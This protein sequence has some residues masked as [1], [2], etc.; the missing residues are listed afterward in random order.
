MTTWADL[1]NSPATLGWSVINVMRAKGVSTKTAIF[2]AWLAAE[3]D[4]TGT[5]TDLTINL[6]QTGID[7]LTANGFATFDGT[8][9]VATHLDSDG[10]GRPAHLRRVPG[11]DFAL[12]LN[13]NGVKPTDGT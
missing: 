3:H 5:L 10:S 8:T 12:E 7:F 9:V 4:P 11:N 2:N 13:P 1:T 6:V